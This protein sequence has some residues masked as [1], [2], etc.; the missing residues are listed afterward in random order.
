MYL[1]NT[2]HPVCLYSMLALWGILLE[3]LYSETWLLWSVQISLQYGGGLP[4]EGTSI[5]ILYRRI[6]KI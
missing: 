3:A 1:Q 4:T 6:L 2:D 5:N